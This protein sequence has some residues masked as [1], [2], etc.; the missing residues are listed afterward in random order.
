MSSPG[1]ANW[2]WAFVSRA[3]RSRR[4]VLIFVPI[5]KEKTRA[6]SSGIRE[7]SPETVDE[8]FFIGGAEGGLAVGDEDDLPGAFFLVFRFLETVDRN[9]EGFLDGGSP[10]GPDSLDELLGLLAIFLIGGD[11][12]LEERFAVG[13][14]AHDLEAIFRVEGIEAEIESF[15]GLVEFAVAHR[16]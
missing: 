4:W 16:G 2:A 7:L 10:D 12:F 13:G 8:D 3:R 9:G 11:E 5:P 1:R 15:L 14:K 6:F